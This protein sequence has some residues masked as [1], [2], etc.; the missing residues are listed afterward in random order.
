MGT[1]RQLEPVK[2]TRVHSRH[3]RGCS[4]DRTEPGICRTDSR[5]KTSALWKPGTALAH[6]RSTWLL[7]RRSGTI[8]RRT[9][10]TR[11]RPRR[12]GKT[13]A[14][15]PRSASIG[16]PSERSP[17]HTGDTLSPSSTT[18]TSQGGR[19]RTLLHQRAPGPSQPSTPHRRSSRWR[20]VPSRGHR[21]GRSSPRWCTGRHRN[22]T[23]S[24]C[25]P[26]CRPRTDRQGMGRSGCCQ[27]HWRRCRS[28]RRSTC[29]CLALQ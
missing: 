27:S 2:T 25:P 5:S 8:L 28:C 17:S 16:Y 26:R 6:T 15:T 20:A 18:R 4:S 13:P 29:C 21:G 23:G 9:L 24:S 14:G 11:S 19:D 22:R 7:H 1:G 12:A 3:T 10:G